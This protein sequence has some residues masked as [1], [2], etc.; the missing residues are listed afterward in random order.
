MK[1][2]PWYRLFVLLSLIV[3][4]PFVTSP[5]PVHSQ[6]AGGSGSGGAHPGAGQEAA[7]PMRPNVS[8]PRGMGH[9]VRPSDVLGQT[10]VPGDRAQALEERLRNGQI[11]RPIAQDQVSDRLEELHKGSGARSPGDTTT[12]Q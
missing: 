12:G 2:T 4:S 5:P 3:L 1:V 11:E 8:K 10:P 9:S 7:P 6:A